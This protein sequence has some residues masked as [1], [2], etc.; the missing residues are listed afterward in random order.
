M[1]SDEA[2]LKSN[3]MFFLR[4]GH[5]PQVVCFSNDLRTL[6]DDMQAQSAWGRYTYSPNLASRTLL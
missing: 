5:T 2:L 6:S 1:R 4:E 3:L